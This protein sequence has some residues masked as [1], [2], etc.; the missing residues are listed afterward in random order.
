MTITFLIYRSINVF[1]RI[2]ELLIFARI[3]LSFI[4]GG[5]YNQ[6]F[7]IIYQLTEPILSPFRKLIEKLNINTGMIDLS[8]LLAILALNLISRILIRLLFWW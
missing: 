1:V 8:P 6:R 5:M 3:I 7:G 4:G 2:V